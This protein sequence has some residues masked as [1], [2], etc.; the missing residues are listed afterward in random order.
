MTEQEIP[1]GNLNHSNLQHSLQG[2]AELAERQQAVKEAT[3][4]REAFFAKLADQVEGLTFGEAY[5]MATRFKDPK[6]W[7]CFYR[8]VWRN[9]SRY[10]NKYV[11][12]QVPSN[13]PQHI[14]PNMTSMPEAVK[15]HLLE[16][17]VEYVHYCNQ[18]AV[19]V[20]D[21]N[22]TDSGRFAE[23]MN[24]AIT[25]EDVNAKDWCLMTP[26]LE[27]KNAIVTVE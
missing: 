13:V 22:Q 3:E 17:K 21:K 18:I 19:V 5:G 24:Y 8:I 26:A 27:N 11:Y 6:Q 16:R 4:K 12:V 9:D 23:I 14:I 15:H 25:P 10:I 20:L 7:L 1:Y 2:L